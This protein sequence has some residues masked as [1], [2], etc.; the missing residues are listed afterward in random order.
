VNIFRLLVIVPIIFSTDIYARISLT[1]TGYLIPD[2]AI[3]PADSALITLSHRP[4]VIQRADWIV[5]LDKG[6]LKLTGTP[7]EL[8]QLP[9]KHL[10]FLNP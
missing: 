7:E 9:G 1:I 5:L 10:D 4:R 6:E 8:S 3:A 2:L